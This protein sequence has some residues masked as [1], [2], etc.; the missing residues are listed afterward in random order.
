[1][2]FALAVERE[3]H[4]VELVHPLSLMELEAPAFRLSSS[5]EGHSEVVVEVPMWALVV[6]LW[7][8]STQ[9]L[10]T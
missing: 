4:W 1:M 10:V 6:V 9:R 2:S 3:A 5:G 8:V 7:V